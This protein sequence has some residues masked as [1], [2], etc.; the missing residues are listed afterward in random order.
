M[1]ACLQVGI[2]ERADE[3]G[4]IGLAKPDCGRQGLLVAIAQGGI[5][6]RSTAGTI[7]PRPRGRYLEPFRPTTTTLG[8]LDIRS[9]LSATLGE[10]R[11]TDGAQPPGRVWLLPCFSGS[12]N[13]TVV[14]V[15]PSDIDLRPS[16]ALL[17][18]DTSRSR[19]VAPHRRW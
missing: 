10:T 7:P 15:P 4:D 1:S 8:L 12:S 16:C 5:G 9:S 18:L 3:S 13:C 14:R 6:Q 2:H 17:L 11:L 19:A